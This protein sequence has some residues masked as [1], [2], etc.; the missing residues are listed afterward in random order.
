VGYVHFD[1][2]SIV[3]SYNSNAGLN[4]VAA[5]PPGVWTV[6]LPGRGTSPTGNLQVTAVD[7]AKPARCKVGNWTPTAAGQ[8][9]NPPFHFA[10][11]M[12]ESPVT[13]GPYPPAPPWSYANGPGTN[14]VQDALPFRAVTFP[15]VGMLPGH[16]QV[17]AFGSGHEY[18]QL[19]GLWTVSLSNAYADKVICCN[20]TSFVKHRAFVTYTSAS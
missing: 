18:C 1:G 3:S 8:V 2:T 16:V 6:T 4:S 15:G 14:T 20:G 10:Y 17:T 5:G 11:T 12:D 13:P 19:G 9:A 7:P